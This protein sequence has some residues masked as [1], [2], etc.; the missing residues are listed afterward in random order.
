MK[1]S[2]FG[3]KYRKSEVRAGF[4]LSLPFFLLFILFTVVPVLGSVVMSF[5]NFNMMSLPKF[6]GTENYTRLF[7]QDSI[8]IKAVG[9]TFILALILGPG[10]YILSFVFAWLLNEI[11]PKVRTI[12]TFCFYAPSISGNI[13]VIWQ[14]VFSG[15]SQG[16]LNSILCRLGISSEATLWLKNPETIMPIIIFVSLWSSLGTSFLVFIAGL[17]GVDRSYYEAGAIDG[18]RNRWQE[19]W[20]ITLPLMKPQLLFSAVM[21]ITGSFGV[22]GLIT[23]LCGYPTVNYTAHTIMNHLSDYAGTRFEVGYASAIA[24]VLFAMMYFC[25]IVV[26]KLLSKVGT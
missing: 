1:K 2:N 24:T 20:Y 11:G 4:I 6:V 5:T 7:L 17:Q 21:S 25:N 22:G 19:L 10:G 8:F 23:S 26:Q 12:F 16:Y 9:N 3:K 18:L 14:M 15:D 13:V